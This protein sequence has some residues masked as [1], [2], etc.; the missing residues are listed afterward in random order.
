MTDV[1]VSKIYWDSCVW[2]AW[3]NDNFGL[4]ALCTDVLREAEA[5][6]ITI[7]MS[8]LVLA[9]FA[10]QDPDVNNLVDR[11]LQ[12]SSFILVNLSRA[13]AVRAKTLVEKY[14]G[15]RGADAVHIATALYAGAD[16]FHTTDTRSLLTM[17]D[18]ITEIPIRFPEWPFPQ[19]RLTFAET[20]A[21]KETLK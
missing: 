20:A 13:I 9:E 19:A 1:T 16:V 15:L 17:A 5:H 3:N 4:R 14:S 7:V 10:P 8:T 11:Y 2:I 6:R 21:T 12:R 18:R